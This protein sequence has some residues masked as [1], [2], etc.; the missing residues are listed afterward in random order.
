M[1]GPI[2]S[3]LQ[4][5]RLKPSGLTKCRINVKD[6]SLTKKPSKEAQEMETS[7]FFS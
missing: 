3:L 7:I 6:A 2:D 5:N 1:K 4:R